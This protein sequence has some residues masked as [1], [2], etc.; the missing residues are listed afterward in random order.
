LKIAG[1]EP[2]RTRAVSL[3]NRAIKKKTLFPK[4]KT[5]RHNACILQREPP[6]T[7]YFLCVCV[8]VETLTPEK[9]AATEVT[10]CLANFIAAKVAFF[11]NIKKTFF[12][13]FF[14]IKSKE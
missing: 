13:F 5:S 11:C 2:V 14:R 4:Q 8:C 3:S 10:I 1:G 9:Q 6:K 7:P 12:K